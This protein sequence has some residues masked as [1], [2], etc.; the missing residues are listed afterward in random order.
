MNRF[1]VH[2]SVNDLDESIGFYSKPFGTAPTVTEPNHAK[3]ML[4]DACANFAISHNQCGRTVGAEPAAA[5]P[6]SCSSCG[7]TAAPNCCG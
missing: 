7:P 3:W 5:T 2:V 6:P 1:H 4:E